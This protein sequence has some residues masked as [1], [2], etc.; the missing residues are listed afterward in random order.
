MLLSRPDIHQKIT[1]TPI[2]EEFERSRSFYWTDEL[3]RS[4]D[5]EP[6]SIDPVY[7]RTL[8]KKVFQLTR[9]RTEKNS[10][11]ESEGLAIVFLANRLQQFLLGRKFNFKTN[12][13]TL[14]Y[15]FCPNNQ[16]P[17]ISSARLAR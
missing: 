6:C 15:L 12:L 5:T 8:T 7:E 10:K 3:L 17:K 11:K 16:S 14:P 2:T 4:N 9:E 1:P 13:K